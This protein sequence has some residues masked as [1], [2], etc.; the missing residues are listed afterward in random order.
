MATKNVG[1][2][3]GIIVAAT[4]PSNQTVV[5]Y[6]TVAKLHRVY[7][8]DEAVWAPLSLSVVSSVND[9]SE[10]VNKA[11]AAGGL[12]I[13]T[14]I[15]VKNRDGDSWNTLVWVIGP[16]RIQYVDTMDNMIVEDLAGTGT[17]VRYVAGT[18][19]MFDNVVSIFDTETS[20]VNIEFQPM[21]DA[22]PPTDVVYGKRVI[23]EKETLIS[24]PMSSL[25]SKAAGQSLSWTLQ[26]LF[27]SFAR[28]MA[29]IIDTQQQ[30]DTHVIGAKQYAADFAAINKLFNEV[31][32][33][34]E[35]WQN[36]APA[37]V[38][39]S[40]L[41]ELNPQTATVAAPNDA[42]AGDSLQTLV[43][44]MQ[45]WYNRLK[46]ATGESLSTSYAAA[47]NKSRYPQAGDTVEQAISI[48]H[49]FLQDF[50]GQASA[51]T[52]GGSQSDFPD[53]P[54]IS[55]IDVNGSVRDALKVIWDAF[56]EFITGDEGGLVLKK[57]VDTN[58][59]FEKAI[60]K[61][62]LGN[63]VMGLINHGINGY[64]P[65]V[66]WNGNDGTNMQIE[67]NH[68]YDASGVTMA[69]KILDP[70]LSEVFDWDPT[71][72]WD[73][74]FYMPAEAGWTLKPPTDQ[75]IGNWVPVL[76][77]K[78]DIGT[79]GTASDTRTLINLRFVPIYLETEQPRGYWMLTRY[80]M[81]S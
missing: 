37:T 66:Q 14:F 80:F 29:A 64:Y 47:P 61:P 30:D 21:T 7:N 27:F 9:F 15:V 62:L 32:K 52:V 81:R 45:G 5:W 1:Q 63:D 11:N 19:Y 55:F 71:K 50:N 28:A 35:D 69:N 72:S 54:Y 2:I 12:T 42:K 17:A 59:I 44:K 58:S 3:A 34:V 25:L 67:P 13:G 41:P 33:I 77:F 6:D 22:V 43:D 65:G 36:N 78:T 51:V 76:T 60:T 49:K 56:E 75:S 79:F 18:N 46:L 39:A 40:G 26:G 70:V 48:L 73:A 31:K 74:W 53:I 57:V 8:V 68:Y 24:R 38:Y 20:K 16:T 4:A 23:N 10:L